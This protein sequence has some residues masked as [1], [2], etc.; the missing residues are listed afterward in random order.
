MLTTSTNSPLAAAGN[1]AGDLLTVGN[2]GRAAGGLVLK[3]GIATHVLLATLLEGEGSRVFGN[4]LGR[5]E[6]GHEDGENAGVELHFDRRMVWR[7]GL[8]VECVFGVIV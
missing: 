7:C 1:I 8:W 6:A 2:L 4:G 3:G 5:G